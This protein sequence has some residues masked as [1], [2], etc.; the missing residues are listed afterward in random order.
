M[1]E[2]IEKIA[3]KIHFFA[4][5]S[6][7]FAE[8][9]ICAVVHKGFKLAAPKNA[10]ILLDHQKV[11]QIFQQQN[12]RDDFN[13]EKK[14]LWRNMEFYN[15]I[16]IGHIEGLTLHNPTK[17]GIESRKT[18]YI[19][20]SDT[21]QKKIAK[22]LHLSGKNRLLL[23]IRVLLN[24]FG[25]TLPGDKD[26]F[27]GMD[28]ANHLKYATALLSLFEEKTITKLTFMI[29]V[30]DISVKFENLE[31]DKLKS[32]NALNQCYEAL[33]NKNCF[34]MIKDFSSH[35]TNSLREQLKV[36]KDAICLPKVCQPPKELVYL[37]YVA[38]RMLIR[39][40]KDNTDEDR[41][42]A[43][44]TIDN[45]DIGYSSRMKVKK[46]KKCSRIISSTENLNVNFSSKVA[47]Y[48]KIIGPEATNYLHIIYENAHELRHPENFYKD[49]QLQKLI[50]Y[51]RNK[52]AC[53]AEL[54]KRYALAIQF[55]SSNNFSESFAHG[56]VSRQEKLNE[57]YQAYFQSSALNR[58]KCCSALD[59][60]N[61]IL[62]TK[63][64]FYT[65]INWHML[66]NS[67]IK[68]LKDPLIQYI[69]ENVLR[70]PLSFVQ[71][72]SESLTFDCVSDHQRFEVIN[73]NNLISSIV[74]SIN[75]NDEEMPLKIVSFTSSVE[76]EEASDTK[77]Y[78]PLTIQ[79]FKRIVEIY[80]TMHQNHTL[81]PRG[82]WIQIHRQLLPG[83][84][85][86]VS[87]RNATKRF[88]KKYNKQQISLL[89]ELPEELLDILPA[90]EINSGH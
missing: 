68:D 4:N 61:T 83:V 51:D 50:D 16:G 26:N 3:Q 1:E 76:E 19:K 8:N 39:F 86:A 47:D 85:S 11:S 33:A 58:G 57:V 72:S 36:F 48:V 70:F 20:T 71:R 59:V 44:F 24:Q 10:A 82:Y 65:F 73:E 41:F 23:S 13:N 2:K 63:D 32:S 89:L 74:P 84:G 52:T 64:V 78:Y 60:Y 88:F 29:E 80:V 67:S 56:E 53:L 79:H 17:D 49:L 6:K 90:W 21:I 27:Y 42:V 54:F 75:N 62:E 5:N 34:V 9:F 35:V 46:Y 87:I 77:K 22:R 43:R 45:A 38:E 40:V 30:S 12:R 66:G 7:H 37:V 25:C 14:S 31:L 55:K 81:N 18:F 69:K 15:F 28:D